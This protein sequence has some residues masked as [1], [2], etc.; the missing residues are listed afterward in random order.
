MKLQIV[1]YGNAILR[2]K[3]AKIPVPLKK[4]HVQL[5]QDMLE[6]MHEAKG[7]GLAAQQVRQALQLA[8]V[9]VTGIEDRPSKMWIKQQEVNPVDYMPMVLI[10][11]QISLIK[12]KESDIEGCLSFPGIEASINRPRRVK[13]KMHKPDGSIF[14]F[15]AGGLLGRAIQHEYDHLQGVLFTDLMNSEERKL[16][17]D[18]IEAIRTGKFEVSNAKPETNF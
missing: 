16:L 17:R 10:N 8:V 12:T 18:R 11:P 9:D 1:L 7:I 3:G 14:E 2:K 5:I 4:E 15:E 6:T 13:I